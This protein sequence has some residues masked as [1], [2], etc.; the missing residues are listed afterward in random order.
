MTTNDSKIID[1]LRF[2]LMLLVVCTHSFVKMESR[3]FSSFFSIAISHVIAHLAVPLFFV[4]SGYLFFVHLED[5]NWNEWKRKMRSRLKS[6]LIPYLLWICV[7]ILVKG[8]WQHASVLDYIRFFW[9]STVWGA[10]KIDFLG[11]SAATTAPILYPFW[12]LRDLLVVLSFTPL[13]YVCLRRRGGYSSI[14]PFLFL[15]ILFFL[16]AT[17]ISLVI[18]GFS[19]ESF[20]FFSLGGC[21]SLHGLSLTE[22][23]FPY[24]LPLLILAFALLI[25]EIVLDS[26]YS[27]WGNIIHPFFIIH[28][29]IAT[30]CAAALLLE[31][32]NPKN[33]I[34]LWVEN[35][36]HG[37]FFLF[38]VHA[39][40]LPWVGKMLHFWPL[41]ALLFYLLRI[42]IVVALC[43]ISYRIMF[44]LSP[45]L[46]HFM[47]CR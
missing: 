6:V 40:I 17:R 34:M 15:A 38:A 35:Q 1:L 18:P 27:Y 25:V 22:V 4:F 45:R 10:G 29:I 43:M 9:N 21:L 37:S 16:Y 3:C 33:R 47:G 12:F 20:F 32:V 5:W 14:I 30:L 46:C 2:P 36:R 31:K 8:H 24:R 44:R 7:C 11:H 42:L 13:L 26:N 19:I 41:P 39:M 28:G 23:F